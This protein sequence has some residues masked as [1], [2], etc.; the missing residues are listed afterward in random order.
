MEV[1]MRT[2]SMLAGLAVL[3]VGAA[4][5]KKKRDED[6]ETSPAPG[7]AETYGGAPPGSSEPEPEPGDEGEFSG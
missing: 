4:L 3:L 5:V 2:S 7:R 6:K 1:F